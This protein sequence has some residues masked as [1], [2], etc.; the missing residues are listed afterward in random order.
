MGV[1][2]PT[3]GSD[4]EPTSIE[5]GIAAVDAT[6]KRSE[7]SFPASSDDVRAELG[8]EQIPYDV[9]GN[10][11]LLETALEEVPQTEFES[12]QELL[13]ALHPVFETYREEHSSGFMQQLRSLFPF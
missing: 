7:L 1:R 4:D 3:N 2:P 11:I 13:N 6:L 9:H 8:D 5:F 10:A 12:R